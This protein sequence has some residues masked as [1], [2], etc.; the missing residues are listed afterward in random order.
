MANSVTAALVVVVGALLSCAHCSE[1]NNTIDYPACAGLPGPICACGKPDGKPNLCYACSSCGTCLNCHTCS[2]CDK[3]KAPIPVTPPP[4]DWVPRINNSRMLYSTASVLPQLPLYPNIG[5]GYIGGTLGCFKDYQPQLKA[6]VLHI[7]GVFSGNE[8]GSNRADIPGAFSVYPAK[9]G[10]GGTMTDVE[11]GGAALDMELGVF[12]NRSFLP[13]C[14]NATLEQ[15]WFAH[16]ANRSLIVYTMQI[17]A[18]GEH[19]LNGTCQIM[20]TSCNQ[21]STN[22]DPVFNFSTKPA[23]Q[24]STITQPERSTEE[25]TVVASAYDY[26]SNGTVVSFNPSTTI[27]SYYAVFKTSLPQEG[28]DMRDPLQAV[29]KEYSLYRGMKDG[30]LLQ[31]HI[32]AW[33]QQWE[34]RISFG[35]STDNGRAVAS[36]VNSSFYY[37]LSAARSDWPYSTSPGGLANNA[38]QG[39]TFWD[40]ETWQFPPYAVFHPELAPSL[41]Q[42]RTDRLPAALDRARTN[43]YAGGQFPWESGFSGYNVCPWTTGADFEQHVTGDV[44]MAFRLQYYLSKDKEWM[45]NSAWPVVRA[46]AEFWASRLSIDN[47]T[48]NYT[49]LGVVGPDERS[50]KVDNEAYTNALAGEVLKFASEVALDLG[51]TPGANWTKLASKV[52]LPVVTGVYEGGPI[53]LQ[54]NQY[55][56]GQIITQADVALLQYPLEIAG[57]S[58]ELK[59]ND[60][61][62]YTAITN[63]NGFYTGDSSYSISWIA[64]GN[65]TGSDAQFARAFLYLNGF[66]NGSVVAPHFNPFNVWKERASTGEHLNFL[67]GAGGF[68]QNVINGYGGLRARPDR[69]ELAPIS[70]PNADNVTFTSVNYAGAKFSFAYNNSM[71]QF[72]LSKLPKNAEFFVVQN[73]QSHS[74]NLGASLYL[75]VGAA[76]VTLNSTQHT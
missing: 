37:L 70:V 43:G 54:D 61:A 48:G 30:A 2:I 39:H 22:M 63:Q 13:G 8:T 42:Y 33:A 4:A 34:G 10:T 72:T 25:K 1:N 29:E 76:Y 16:R 23:T 49:V 65:R 75:P 5:N 31:S 15:T 53:H 12:Y 35:T 7:G 68:L 66:P 67:T 40:L 46:A 11:Y 55:K 71:M 58:E 19:H 47:S 59:K 74:I 24:V 69:M 51:E 18:N 26:I 44:A 21:N 60:L 9:A 38:Y 17:I 52:F 20:L 50:G 6:G 32:Q 27:K 3:N 56:K 41:L 64:Q 36:A 62:Y 73:S 14:G 28:A 57:I 45:K